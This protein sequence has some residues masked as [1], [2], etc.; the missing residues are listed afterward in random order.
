MIGGVLALVGMITD[1]PLLIQVAIG[2]LVL[3]WMLRFRVS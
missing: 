3:S 2:V 1:T